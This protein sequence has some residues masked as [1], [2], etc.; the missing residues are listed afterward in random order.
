MLIEK[1][2]T[3]L[4]NF[5][6]VDASIRSKDYMYF[7]A[8]HIYELDDENDDEDDE[9]E[10]ESTTTDTEILPKQA[11][12][13]FAYY[14]NKPKDKQWGFQTIKDIEFMKCASASSPSSQFV[15][16]GMSGSVCTIGNG[17]FAIEK[18]IPESKEG[19]LRGPVRQVLSIGGFVYVVQGNRG[20]CKKLG[21]NKWQ[22]LCSNL[23]VS[24]SWQ[25]RD[26]RGFTCAAG[27]SENSIYAGGG[28]GDLWHYDGANWRELTFSTDA[29][30]ETMCI[31]PTGKV[32][33]GCKSGQVY[34]GEGDD[35]K[36]ISAGNIVTS[37]FKSM[38]WY[39]DKVWCAS[40]YG[41]WTITDEVIE[42]AN[43]PQHI[44]ARGGHLS[45]GDG[46]LLLA[47]DTGAA[48]FDGTKWHEFL[49]FR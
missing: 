46:L 42:K 45:V 36:K 47:G 43:L 29:I 14:P 20:I 30:I 37:S 7:I 44:H 34:V 27:L 48:Y 10:N 3:L 31:D 38:V 8:S 11:I 33:I 9:S 17:K 32:Y 39:Q 26:E 21:E 24:K 40:D 2:L 1:T 23:P 25:A 41:V 4:K 49:S 22:T 16:V 12:R 18:N 28:Q 15:G 35:W 6:I 19:P 13:I 5:S